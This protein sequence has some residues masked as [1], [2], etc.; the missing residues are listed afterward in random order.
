[1]ARRKHHEEHANHEAWAI[2]YGDLITLL[3]AFFVVMYAISSVNTGKYRV[4]SNSLT[5]AF[6]GSTPA[7]NPIQIASLQS[8]SGSER[9]PVMIMRGAQGPMSPIAMQ[10]IANL[11]RI[12]RQLRQNLPQPML[13]AD[14]HEVARARD[15]LQKISQN[16][17]NALGG[18]IERDLVAVKR[19]DLWVEVEIKSDILFASGVALPNQQAV[20]ILGT[21]AES[22]VQVPNAI[23]VEGHTDNRPI[24]TS[25]FPSN[26]ELSS[27]RA[28]GVLR[29]FADRGIGPNRLS[30]IGY[31][32]QRPIAD[33]GT[34]PGRNANRRVVVVIL[35]DIPAN[36]PT[37]EDETPVMLPDST[38]PTPPGAR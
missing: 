20:R 14:R 11:P 31:G 32:E 24:A 38:E 2:P 3:L 36:D 26:W 15:D 13:A 4:L 34:A 7:L 27:A 18:L 22:L 29:I 28:A 33:N 25:Q 10:R 16:V 35:A 37:S 1:M 17:E 21:L 12:S 6:G 30:L 5:V 19:N 8:G 23:R 9:N